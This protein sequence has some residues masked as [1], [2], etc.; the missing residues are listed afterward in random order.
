MFDDKEL[1]KSYRNGNE[2]SI[3]ILINKHKNLLYNLSNKLTENSYDAD[4]LFQE[5]W[6]K[7]FKNIDRYD[8]N[9]SFETWIYTIC[10]NTYKDKYSKKKRWLNIIKDY[11]NNEDKDGVFKNATENKL[12]PEQEVV[13]EEKNSLLLK[14][15]N[16]LNDTYR[17]PLILF[18]FKDI[19]YKEIS[20]ILDIPTGTVKSRLNYGKKKLKSAL[21]EG[22]YG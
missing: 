14:E 9:K 21:K 15:I 8:E 2:N 13:K 10:I 18:Y 1:I 16:K 20:N 22:F 19:S 17:I 3:D 6:V 5:T 12:L 11:F 4:D 7:V